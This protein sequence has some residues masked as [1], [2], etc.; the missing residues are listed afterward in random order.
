MSAANA[1]LPPMQPDRFKP[2][3][4]HPLLGSMGLPDIH[5]PT[6]NEFRVFLFSLR[7][8]NVRNG[9]GSPKGK[10]VRPLQIDGSI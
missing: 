6:S 4:R 8:L 3:A 10:I 9:Y 2:L 5:C 1:C 7:T